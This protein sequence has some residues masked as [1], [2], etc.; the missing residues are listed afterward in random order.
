L[1]ILLWAELDS[2]AVAL[3]WGTLGLIVFEIGKSFSLSPMIWQ[4]HLLA[5]LSFGRLFMANFVAPTEVMGI[6]H[7]V[8]TV[9]PI[10]ALLYYFRS[11]TKAN[12]GGPNKTFFEFPLSAVYSYGAAILLVVLARFE[13]GRAN[14]VMAMALMFVVFLVLGIY[15]RDRDFR[16]QSY[17]I[18]GMTFAR[19]WATNVYLVGSFY[20]IPE[21]IAT[22]LPSIAAFFT[23]TAISMSR[24]V[25][26]EKAGQTKII[27]WLQLGDKN[28]RVLFSFLGTVLLA[29]LTYYELPSNL[30]TM[31]WA[32]EA[33]VL[34]AVGFAVQEKFFRIYGLI[35]L[36]I[37]L[38]KL[39]IIDLEGVETIFRRIS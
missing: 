2:V 17:I 8:V 28:N 14:A 32:I 13:F 31:A 15:L 21:R 22:L 1:T 16:Y 34:I 10:V 4:G 37:C 11:M 27:R 36:F 33:L 38:I 6:S 5:G 35:L 20:G 30:V 25:P 24:Q 19:S 9:V 18:A 26:Q 12:S 3:A 39:V 29:V 23:A 7:R